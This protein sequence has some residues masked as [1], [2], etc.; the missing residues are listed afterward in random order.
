MQGLELM[1]NSLHGWSRRAKTTNPAMS[2]IEIASI[3]SDNS[4]NQMNRIN[5]LW[6]Y[7]KLCNPNHSLNRIQI[8]LIF[9]I[10][11]LKLLMP[12]IE[13]KK[14]IRRLDVIIILG[15]HSRIF[16]TIIKIILLQTTAVKSFKI[17]FT[18]LL[19]QNGELINV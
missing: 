11:I 8:R 19:Q 2:P 12:K 9:S 6:K 17:N 13:I 10:Y 15:K 7:S 14:Q 3:T 4:G 18:N 5:C 16:Q 1:D